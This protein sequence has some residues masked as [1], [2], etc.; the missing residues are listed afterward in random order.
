MPARHVRRDL[1]AYC[2][3]E[4][5]AERAARVEAHLKECRRCRDEHETI[6]FAAGMAGS[7]ARLSAPASLW[8]EVRGR[9][10]TPA[11]EEHRIGAGRWAPACSAAL[12]LAALTGFAVWYLGVRQRLELVAAS[13][14]PSAFEVAAR[15]AHLGRLAGTLQFDIET[16]SP[17]ELKAWLRE[18]AHFDLG[19]AIARPPEDGGRFRVVGGKVVLAGGARA[20]LVGYEVDSRPVTLLTAPLREVVDAPIDL[21]FE[22]KVTSRLDAQRGMKMLT[23]GADGQ[24]YVL[25]SDLPGLG[26]EAC[27]ICHTDP[28]R[29]R[30][31]RETRLASGP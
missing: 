10:E 21:R 19:L 7:L 6:R 1:V 20:A 8:D 2:H 18:Q 11:S 24:A 30:L 13:T 22:K 29:R 23:W 28:G 31:I 12:L 25:V 26:T 3:G 4:L 16:L 14:A 17:G 27:S 5:A 15:E 9:L